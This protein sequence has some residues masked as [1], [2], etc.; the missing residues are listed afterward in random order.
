M[1]VVYTLKFVNLLFLHLLVPLPEDR[2]ETWE[3]L[4][5]KER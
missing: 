3:Q 5:L 4:N 1:I 2:A